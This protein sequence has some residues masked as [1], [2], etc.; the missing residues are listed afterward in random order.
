MS[1]VEQLK[2]DLISARIE[3]LDLQI[4]NDNLKR[5]AI[6][7]LTSESERDSC[8]VDLSESRKNESILSRENEVL[9]LANI[10][11]IEYIENH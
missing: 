7:A 2:D 4:E 11:M 5:Q 1:E 8:L 9:E 3:I 6:H 10:L